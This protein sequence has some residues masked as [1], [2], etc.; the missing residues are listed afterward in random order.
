MLSPQ[1]SYFK[2]LEIENLRCFGK[3]Q[4]I[5]FHQNDQSLPNWTII[6]GNNGTGKTTILKTLALMLPYQTHGRIWQK[7]IDGNYFYRNND[8]NPAIHIYF[9]THNNDSKIDIMYEFSPNIIG[10]IVDSAITDYPHLEKIN[11]TFHIFGYGASRTI[12]DSALTKKQEFP[13]ASLFD[14][15]AALIN[16]EEWLIRADYLALKNKAQAHSQKR[17]KEM[18]LELFKGEIDDFHIITKDKEPAVL[19]KTDYGWVNLHNLSLGYKTIIAWMVDFARGMF[20]KYPDHENPLAEPAILLIDEIDLHIHPGFQHS[21]IDFLSKIFP[22]TQFIVTA[23]S[24]LIVQAAFEANIV[25]LKKKGDDIQ[26]INDPEIVKNW[27]I[28]QVLTS[29]L[30]GLKGARSPTIEKEN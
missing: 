21:L 30:F 26:V 8:I 25:L 15:N 16:A 10:G 1:Y 29:D 3:K 22:K 9:H 4:R 2:S 11:D 17:I 28:D 20:A 27:R 7:Y 18:L 24:P 13:A 12:S 14:D 23:H 6:I 19:F 5:D